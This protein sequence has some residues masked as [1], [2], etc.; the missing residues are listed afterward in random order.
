MIWRFQNKGF[1]Q[2][3]GK[4]RFLVNFPIV[5]MVLVILFAA[6][7]K[8]HLTPFA[9][10]EAFP[11]VAD[12]TVTIEL[13]ASQSYDARCYP[14]GLK[15][16]WDLDGDLQWDTDY[17]EES[18]FLKHFINPG[19]YRVSVEVINLQGFSSTASDTVVIFGRNQD[20]STM[21]D[22]RDGQQYKTVKINGQWWMAEC[23]NIGEAIDIW[24][25]DQ[26]DNG[27]IE[28]YEYYNKEVNKIH[29]LY[30]WYEAINHQPKSLQGIC[31]DGWHLPTLREITTISYQFPYRWAFEYYGKDGLSGL[32][33]ADG[34]HIAIWRWDLIGLNIHLIKSSFWSSYN[35]IKGDSIQAY[36]LDFT[37][38]GPNWELVSDV[39]FE[40]YDIVGQSIATVRCVKDK[41]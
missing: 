38:R 7:S 29:S 11:R 39:D 30:S 12:S 23:L 24:T 10:L 8:E 4:C 20:V 21:I 36:T 14:P 2:E 31:P 9:F 1:K 15:Y 3:S 22:P 19:T 5:Q 16:R 13:N 27:I 17:L 26:T 32:N 28:R 37:W 18:I 33:L 40:D 25:Q 41:E 34:T 6:C 35:I